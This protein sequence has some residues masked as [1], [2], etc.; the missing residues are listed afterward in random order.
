[1]CCT[2]TPIAIRLCGI[3]RWLGG[4]HVQ[5]HGPAWRWSARA[6]QLIEA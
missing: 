6:G 1:M 2:A 5:V 4:V 3:D